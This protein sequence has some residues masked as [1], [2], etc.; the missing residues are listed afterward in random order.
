MRKRQNEVE[1]Q[2]SEKLAA[3]VGATPL[4]AL[5]IS[6]PQDQDRMQK[7]AQSSLDPE[8]VYL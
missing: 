6:A 2:R 8:S 7:Q 1:E 4:L 3:L 5:E